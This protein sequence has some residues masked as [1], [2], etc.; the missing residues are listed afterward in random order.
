MEYIA[1]TK[2]LEIVYRTCSKIEIDNYI[3]NDPW[4]FIGR[5]IN[6]LTVF[7]TNKIN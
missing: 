7:I 6:A 3:K 2:E 1:I 4:L 5:M